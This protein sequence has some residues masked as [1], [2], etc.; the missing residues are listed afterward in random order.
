MC[1]PIAGGGIVSDMGIFRISIAVENPTRRGTLREVTEVMVDTGAEYT[2]VSG[3]VLEDLGIG[4]E[5]RVA[6][7]TADGRRIERSVGFANIHVAGTSAPDIIVFAEPGDL[8]LLGAR[9]LEGL[10]LR[11]DVTTK[12]LVPA[13]PVPAAVIRAA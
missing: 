1:V 5:R 7:V 12:Q 2:W 6:F 8:M 3:A 11:V 9:S 4:A 10:N 13:G